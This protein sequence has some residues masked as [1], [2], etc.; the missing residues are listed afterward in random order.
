MNPD[1][2]MS[3]RPE[4]ARFSRRHRLPML[5][6]A[7]IIRYRLQRERL[8]RRIAT[9]KLVRPEGEFTAIS[10]GSDVDALFHVALVKGDVSS[11]QPVLTRVH[12]A[13]LVGDLLGGSECDCGPQLQQAL[14]RIADEGRGVVVYLQKDQSP[15]SRLVCTHVSNEDPV[16]G[17]Q[18][19][20]RLREFGVGAQ[21]LKDLGLRTLRLLTNNPKKIVGLESYALE[22][23][24]QVPLGSPPQRKR[25]RPIA[26]RRVRR[27][28][29]APSV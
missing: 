14:R 12:R 23:V 1:G 25:P 17:H 7:D 19:R 6:V 26:A 11:G 21:I 27:S 5:S 24:E 10:Y 3:R 2:T 4:L 9:R 8:V 22:V 20:T 16:P 28:P 29:H 15:K 13:C 18:D